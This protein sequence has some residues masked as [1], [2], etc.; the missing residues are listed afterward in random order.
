MRIL[1]AIVLSSSILV[2]CTP[3]AVDHNVQTSSSARPLDG[4]SL[5]QVFRDVLLS[6]A[7]SAGVLTD[8]P[9]GEVFRAN[10]GYRRILGRTGQ[11]GT[12]AIEG[13][14]LCVMG[15]DFPKQCRR[16]FPQGGGTC[17]LIDASDKS[18]ATLKLSPLE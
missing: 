15:A 2:G 7:L 14:L 5:R 3:T 11:E 10:G 13:N 18:P 6:P 16:V 1:T 4:A 8:H 12:F 9:P 17:V